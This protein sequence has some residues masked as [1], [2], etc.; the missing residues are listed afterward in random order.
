MTESNDPDAI[1]S[2]V[3]RDALADVVRQ[4]P[5]AE[6]FLLTFGQRQQIER[7]ADDETG[8]LL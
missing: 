4:A 5:L 7:M 8:G 6:A 3:E 2:A 1:V